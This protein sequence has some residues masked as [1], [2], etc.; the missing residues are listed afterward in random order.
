M[1]LHELKTSKGFATLQILELAMDI[2]RIPIARFPSGDAK[3]GSKLLTR[4]ELDSMVKSTGDFGGDNRAG[5]PRTLVRLLNHTP[6]RTV[7]DA[8]MTHCSLEGWHIVH[9]SFR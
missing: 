6:H 1:L 2:G 5:L 7:L 8:R 9:A 3:L 4:E